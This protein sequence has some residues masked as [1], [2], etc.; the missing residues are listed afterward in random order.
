[1]G[2]FDNFPYSNFHEMNID[3]VLQKMLELETFVKNYTAVNNVSFAGIWDIRK[4][5]PQWS[6]VSDGN[7]TYMANK[8]VPAG[9]AISN[10]EYWL[11]LA[12]L[13]PRIGTLTTEVALLK[14][15]V[16]NLASLM[17]IDDV[18][19]YGDSY[20][21]KWPETLQN[22]CNFKHFD[23]VS[24]GGGGYV[25]SGALG[26]FKDSIVALMNSGR[27]NNSYRYII[28]EGGI[29]DG[30]NYDS[31]YANAVELFTLLKTNFPNAT[32]IS[33]YNPAPRVYPTSVKFAVRNASAK[34]GIY[35]AGG[36]YVNLDPADSFDSG[37]HVHPNA[38]GYAR[39]AYVAMGALFGRDVNIGYNTTRINENGLALRLTAGENGFSIALWGQVVDAIPSGLVFDG[40]V[41]L[42]ARP[43]QQFNNTAFMVR[44][45]SGGEVKTAAAYITHNGGI[46][47][48][49]VQ[50]GSTYTLL[51][52]FIAYDT[53]GAMT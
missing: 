45:S 23:Y 16:E 49:D 43:Y 42:A 29:N 8:P 53:L 21:A 52:Q 5:Y 14:Q 2:F 9:I 48:P 38:E 36:E 19:C 35:S 6:V 37:D 33:L 28:V 32:I 3:W 41:P 26:T 50:A 47:L 11:Y 40:K 46:Q 25:A 27:L 51:T 44:Y 15:Q 10:K 13:D 39:V 18:F 24:N 22:L 31:V 34:V 17:K 7:K 20:A 12:D 1:M 4:Q 30:E